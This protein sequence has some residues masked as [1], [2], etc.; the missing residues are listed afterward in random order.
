[1]TIRKWNSWEARK[2]SI[3]EMIDKSVA[4]AMRNKDQLGMY[5]TACDI[6]KDD[7]HD[8]ELDKTGYAP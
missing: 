8:I 5:K 6:F 2:V 7:K 4:K 3:E 1:M